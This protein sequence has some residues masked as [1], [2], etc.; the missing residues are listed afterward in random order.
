M[1][2]ENILYAII[3]LLVG[4]LGTVLVLGVVNKNKQQEAPV[5]AAMPGGAP[6]LADVQQQIAE[7]EKVVAQD[8]KNLQAWIHLGNGYFDTNQPQKA[9]NA[10]GKALE[11]DPN[12]PNVL[13]DQG[14]MFKNIGWYDKAVA[15]FEKAA[16][17]DP[18]HMQSLYNL[19]VVYS[20]DLKQ[21]DK[22][23]AAW[24]RL[25]QI[26]ST[27]PQAQQVKGMIEQL[28]SNPAG[29]NPSGMK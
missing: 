19:G 2:K 25:L 20:T 27:S 24:N 1:N 17:L 14:V 22:A 8:P 21:P 3:A 7:A 16:Q 13:T 12:N 11:I 29:A 10:Y 15:N 26:D 9:I 6:S 23:I 18:K 28:K 5:G 4:I